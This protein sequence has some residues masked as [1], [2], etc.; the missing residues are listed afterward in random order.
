MWMGLI[1]GLPMGAAIGY[2]LAV[3][4]FQSSNG[5]KIAN[6]SY[7]LLTE[8]EVLKAKLNAVSER[9]SRLRKEVEDSIESDIDRAE[10]RELSR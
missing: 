2:V 4:L 3:L 5:D 1:I 10:E 7:A 9:Y 8:I 6:C